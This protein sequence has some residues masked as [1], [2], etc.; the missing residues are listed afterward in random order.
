MA[1]ILLDWRP[2]ET[3]KVG[4]CGGLAVYDFILFSY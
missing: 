1:M 4:S 3:E 2:A